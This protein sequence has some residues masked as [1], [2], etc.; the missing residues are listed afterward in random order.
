MI[1]Q[2][3]LLTIMAASGFGSIL[4]VAIYFNQTEDKKEEF[5]WGLACKLLFLYGL[6][7]AIFLI[8]LIW[9]K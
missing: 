3:I 4:S 8:G 6:T 9:I 7:I 5:W 1:A 2:K